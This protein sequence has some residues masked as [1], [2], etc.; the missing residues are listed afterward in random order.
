M[1][2]PASTTRAVT[3]TADPHRQIC[4]DAIHDLK[5]VLAD[6]SALP[7][8]PLL[9]A[10]IAILQWGADL[11]LLQNHSYPSPLETRALALARALLGFPTKAAV[12]P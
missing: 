5:C 3:P 8:V 9:D 12:Q 10:Q 6:T 4:L 1:N 11:Y 2:A 7:D